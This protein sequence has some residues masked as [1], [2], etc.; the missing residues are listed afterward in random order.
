MSSDKENS[1]SGQA[2]VP[3][4]FHTRRKSRRVAALLLLL[5][6]VFLYGNGIR[7]IKKQ[8]Y[9]TTSDPSTLLR[10]G[11]QFWGAFT[12]KGEQGCF[13]WITTELEKIDTGHQLSINGDISVA[14]GQSENNVTINSSSHFSTSKYLKKFS[15]DLKYLSAH[16]KVTNA[17]GKIGT[18]S[19]TLSTDSIKKEFEIEQPGILYLEQVEEG[20]FALLSTGDKS[21]GN[22]TDSQIKNIVGIEVKEVEENQ[23]NQCKPENLSGLPFTELLSGISPQMRELLLKNILKN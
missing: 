3:E 12:T 8:E 21:I 11:K 5:L 1:Q 15:F 18:L 6:S 20:K 22:F 2:V 14:P 23:L 13:T 7:E 9:S 16:L 10:Y 4:Y 19:A 17:T